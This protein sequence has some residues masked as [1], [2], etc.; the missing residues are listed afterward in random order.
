MVRTMI[1]LTPVFALPMLFA[2]VPAA[3]RRLTW[4]HS[5]VGVVLVI[6]SVVA[7]DGQ[8]AS[9][10]LVHNA[11]YVDDDVWATRYGLALRAATAAEA[12]IAVT[13][14]GAI[15]YFSRR[16][17]IDLLGKSDPIVAKR[18]RQPIAFSPGHDKWDY[19]YSIGQLRPDVVAELWYA[20]ESDM[21]AIEGWGYVRVAPWVFV[22]ADSAK[23]D[24]SS[25]TASACMILREDPFLLGSPR[26]FVADINGLAAPYCR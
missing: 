15:P 2:H 8:A 19:R 6:A 11:P 17:A 5:V 23:V 16:P 12:T 10:W 26:R 14:A 21:A 7:I 24:R 20:S 13:W 9:L 3:D 4:R 1:L 22:R 25:V 18:P